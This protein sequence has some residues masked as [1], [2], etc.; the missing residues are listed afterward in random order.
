MKIDE[1][2]TLLHIPE[3]PEYVAQVDKKLQ[4][5]FTATHPTIGTPALR[6]L[7]SGGKRLRPILVLAASA[8]QG[9]PINA[10]VISAATA[11]E[12]IHLGSIVH[13]DVLDHGDQRGGER[14]IYAKEGVDSAILIGDYLLAAASIEAAT[15]S[16]TVA[17]V[18]ASTI[19]TMCEGQMQETVG[20][21]STGRS[22][23]EY[24]VSIHKKTAALIGAACQI[25]GLCAEAADASLQALQEYGEAFGIAFQMADDLLD[26]L[27]TP[28]ALG[29]PTHNDI[30]EGVY[31]LPLLLA[32]KGTSRKTLLPLLGKKPTQPVDY[33]VVVKTLLRD[34]SFDATIT[35]INKQNE[36]AIGAL[37]DLRRNEVVDGLTQLPELY[38]NEALAK[39]KILPKKR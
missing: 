1:L 27:A 17:A 14:T 38:F 26:F 8:S 12:L 4:D 20:V 32:L 21:Y 25:G 15:V 34:G 2:A 39:Q 24:R 33:S 16:D 10:D 23:E 3:L 6:L 22:I 35:E 36:R 37:T 30:K 31:T 5:R 18:V 11:I 9:S 29:K 19:A 13:D 28:K 7:A